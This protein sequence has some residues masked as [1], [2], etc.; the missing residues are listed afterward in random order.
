[1]LS[2][3]QED[4]NVWLRYRFVRWRTVFFGPQ[5]ECLLFFRAA[6]RVLR[7]ILARR[8]RVSLRPATSFLRSL[9]PACFP[10]APPGKGCHCAPCRRFA[11]RY[12][13]PRINKNN[14]GCFKSLRARTP[15]RCLF[16]EGTEGLFRRPTWQDPH[17]R[18]FSLLPNRQVWVVH[19]PVRAGVP[20][21]EI[22]VLKIKKVVKV[23]LKSFQNK[24][25]GVVRKLHREKS[26]GL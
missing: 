5:N 23:V 7:F 1:M 4:I 20:P 3:S 14:Q 8:R 24:Y 11:F 12:N 25:P 9:S 22:F 6:G 15:G 16:L 2:V 10:S 17:Q 18:D 26:H 19:K 13:V 21:E